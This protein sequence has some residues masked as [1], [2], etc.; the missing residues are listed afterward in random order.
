MTT[1]TTSQSFLPDFE[2]EYHSIVVDTIGQDSKNTFTVHL[3]QPLENIVQARL[4]SARIDTTGSNVCYISVEELDTNY[5][6]R[7]SNVYGGQGDL[8]VLTKNFGMVIQNGSDPITFRDNYDIVHQYSTPI[9]KLDRLTCTL[10]NENGVTID[11]G[12]ENFMSFRFVC[13]KKNMPFA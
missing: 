2:Y 7:A 5:A 6:Q 10:R 3:T 4:T 8:S 11:N 12:S 13:K 9:R 1:V